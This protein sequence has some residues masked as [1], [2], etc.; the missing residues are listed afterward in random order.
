LKKYLKF[1]REYKFFSVRIF[2]IVFFKV[3]ELENIKKK[4]LITTIIVLS[5]VGIVGLT[6]PFPINFILITFELIASFCLK[7]YN[8]KT[9]KE[10]K[11]KIKV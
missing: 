7:C 3:I 8:T 1:K 11:N 6:T 10:F 5:I 2:F 4:H 9:N